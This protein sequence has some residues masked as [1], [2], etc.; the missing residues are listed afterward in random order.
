MAGQDDGLVAGVG[1]VG[2]QRG[3]DGAAGRVGEVDHV[4]RNPDAGEHGT[5]RLDGR[6][7]VREQEDAQV[8][9]RRLGVPGAG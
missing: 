1:A 3:V 2:E 9:P 4:G 8:D 6:G 5:Q 7:A